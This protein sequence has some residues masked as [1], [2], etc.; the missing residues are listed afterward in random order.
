MRRLPFCKILKGFLAV[1]WGIL[2]A[3]ESAYAQP[4]IHNGQELRL[5]NILGMHYLARP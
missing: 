4:A 3:G 2:E 1:H 5:L